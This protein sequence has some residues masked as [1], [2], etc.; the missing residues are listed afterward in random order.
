MT[1][2]FNYSTHANTSHELFS[3]EKSKQTLD[4]FL[5]IINNPE[6]GFFH[7]TDQEIHLQKAQELTK[8]FSHKKHFV[9]IGIGGSALGP[10]ML[11]SALRQKWEKTFTVLDN[12]DSDFINDELN[13]IDITQSIF[14]VVSKSGGTA[15]TIAC[16]SIVRNLLLKKGIQQHELQDYFVFCTDPTSGQ[17]R[18]HVTQE[19]YHVLEV[20][21]NI[22]GRFSV[23]SCVGLFP[24]CFM[25]IDISGLYQGANEIKE[26][27]LNQDPQKNNLLNVFSHLAFLYQESTP[28]VNETVLMPYSSKLK[29]LS[30]WF[31]QLWAESLGKYCETTNTRIGLTPIPAYGATDQH[32]QMQLFMD[33]PDNKCVILLN[34]LKRQNDYSLANDLEFDSAQKLSAFNLNELMHA[35]F[36]GS[37]CALK[38][39]KKNIISIDISELNA[40]TVGSL[41]LFFES[42]TAMMGQYLKINPFN[43][44]GVEKGKKY[45]FEYLNSLRK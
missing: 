37:L 45:A 35:E 15:E 38:E 32:S 2:K 3:K 8:I 6:Y 33:G 5:A 23:L 39:N 13:K 4:D 29:D 30:F 20:P 10:Q 42:L 11:I 34:I 40:Q 25:G 19:K 43:Q 44:P 14:Y 27:I 9:Q 12:I 1:F 22:G 7:L 16:Y 36:A 31:V 24:A 17:L 26:S 28:Q 41:V 18:E 21:S